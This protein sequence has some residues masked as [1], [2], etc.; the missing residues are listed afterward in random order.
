MD[1]FDS[2]LTEQRYLPHDFKEL[3]ANLEAAR[4]RATW[5]AHA[6]ELR[7]LIGD[8]VRLFPRRAASTWNRNLLRATAA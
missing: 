2:Q 4:A 7:H 5:G 8:P 1:D 3:V 6:R